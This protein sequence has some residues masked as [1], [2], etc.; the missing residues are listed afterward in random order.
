MFTV[1]LI[2]TVIDL[3]AHRHGSVQMDIQYLYMHRVL[4]AEAVAKGVRQ[5]NWIRDQRLIY[6]IHP[7]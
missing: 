3:R 1:V 4:L 5:D 7:I 2:E 6:R